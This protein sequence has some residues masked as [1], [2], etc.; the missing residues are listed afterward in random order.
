MQFHAVA[1][2]Q[3]TAE[4]ANLGMMQQAGIAGRSGSGGA[5]AAR[6]S[7]VKANVQADSG[8]K[9]NLMGEVQLQ[10]GTETFPLERF[11]DTELVGVITRHARWRPDEQETQQGGKSRAPTGETE[12]S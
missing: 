11:A 8:I 2:D 12:Q 10:F 7:T 1:R 6:V 9:A 3:T 4:V 5:V